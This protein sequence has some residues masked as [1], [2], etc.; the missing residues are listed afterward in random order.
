MNKDKKEGK[1]WKEK[2]KEN[3]I[4]I[5]FLRNLDGNQYKRIC[6]NQEAR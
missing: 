3:Y 1:V 6:E 2:K 5:L 4:S